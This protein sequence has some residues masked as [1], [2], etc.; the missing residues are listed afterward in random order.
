VNTL[1]H[2]AAERGATAAA[3]ALL[4]A[5]ADADAADSLGWTALHFA[6]LGHWPQHES[7]VGVMQLLLSR[8]PPTR[9]N[10]GDA[11]GLTALHVCGN[12]TAVKLL[13]RCGADPL[14]CDKDGVCCTV[15]SARASLT[16]APLL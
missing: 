10:A 8:A 16:D 2:H 11:D 5:G 14:L 7:S 3:A 12:A 4:A 1:S 15:S 9:V 13:L 6:A